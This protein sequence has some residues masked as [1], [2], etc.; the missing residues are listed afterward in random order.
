MPFHYQTHFNTDLTVYKLQLIYM[1]SLRISAQMTNSVTKAIG[2]E[3]VMRAI[4]YSYV[5]PAADITQDTDTWSTVLVRDI[6][7]QLWPSTSLT[8]RHRC[9]VIRSC[10]SNRILTYL[11]MSA[12]SEPSDWLNP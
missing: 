5:L 7:N 9:D 12:G 1:N 3:S 10:D 2:C 8:L 11:I 6:I 4:S